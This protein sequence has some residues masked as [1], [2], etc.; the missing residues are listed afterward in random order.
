MMYGVAGFHPCDDAVGVLA[1]VPVRA[2]RGIMEAQNEGWITRG[3]EMNRAW[4]GDG[5]GRVKCCD[6]GRM[7]GVIRVRY[8]EGIWRS[9]LTRT[10]ESMVAI[11]FKVD[12]CRRKATRSGISRKLA[13]GDG[14]N[15]IRFSVQGLSACRGP[16][17]GARVR[18]LGI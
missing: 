14:I 4:G 17:L 16:R 8:T 7:A 18:T 6:C 15:Q 11:G 5:V 13:I 9:C 2:K 10:R 12:V 1:D 3:R